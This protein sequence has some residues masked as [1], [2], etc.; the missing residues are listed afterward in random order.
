M[1]INIVSIILQDVMK[2]P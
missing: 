2:C 1:D